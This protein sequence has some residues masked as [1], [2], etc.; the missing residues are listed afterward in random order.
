MPDP[1]LSV[2]STHHNYPTLHGET[3]ELLNRNPHLLNPL[4]R[5]ATSL[6]K[7]TRYPECPLH[8]PPL[9]ASCSIKARPNNHPPIYS[10]YLNYQ[11]WKNSRGVHIKSNICQPPHHKTYPNRNR[12]R[13]T[14]TY[15]TTQNARPQQYLQAPYSLPSSR[16]PAH[17]HHSALILESQPKHTLQHTCQ[18]QI[19]TRQRKA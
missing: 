1:N 19:H 16:I 10:H 2:L 8:P 6:P 18:L 17:L 9:A 15:P 14:L 7:P 12:N 3:I 11:G 5:L 13:H 4:Q